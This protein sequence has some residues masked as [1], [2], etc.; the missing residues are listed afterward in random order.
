MGGEQEV[1]E[2][3]DCRISRNN[4]K[5]FASFT[6]NSRDRQDI[7]RAVSN[8]SKL[9]QRE[10]FSCICIFCVHSSMENRFIYL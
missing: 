3:K 1:V 10:M 2:L 4:F 6:E 5:I 8:S 9:K 7:L